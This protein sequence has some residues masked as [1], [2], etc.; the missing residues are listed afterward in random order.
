MPMFAFPTF[1]YSSIKAE[2]LAKAN[3]TKYLSDLND[4]EIDNFET[5][6]E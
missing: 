5:L 1:Y 4:Y 6:F 3:S 2:K